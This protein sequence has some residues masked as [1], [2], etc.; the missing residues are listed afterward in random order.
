MP[1]S[2]PR[3]PEE[4][5]FDGMRRLKQGYRYR[6]LDL[7]TQKSKLFRAYT[8]TIESNTG[9]NAVRR[10]YP[11]GNR[12]MLTAVLSLP[13]QYSRATIRP[14]SRYFP[15]VFARYQTLLD[16]LQH[17]QLV[18]EILPEPHQ[19]GVLEFCQQRKE[20]LNWLVAPHYLRGPKWSGKHINPSEVEYLYETGWLDS[21]L[22]AE[23]EDY[24]CE[25]NIDVG[26]MTVRKVVA[27]VLADD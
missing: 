2:W 26:D 6:Q 7:G 16:E 9:P 18:M 27:W 24:L 8:D 14:R 5:F 15:D 4:R 21:D 13:A 12:R 20:L 10:L 22:T 17:A 11:T 25:H 23:E 1:V 19:A 3:S